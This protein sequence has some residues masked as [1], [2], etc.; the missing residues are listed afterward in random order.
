MLLETRL[1]LICAEEKGFLSVHSL[2]CHSTFINVFLCNENYVCLHLHAL[3]PFV[4]F[5]D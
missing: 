1:T 5:D 2:A 4:L 3:R